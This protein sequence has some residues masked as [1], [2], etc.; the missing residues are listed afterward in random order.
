MLLDI[1]TSFLLINISDTL[2]FSG[3][4][5]SDRGFLTNLDILEEILF[6]MFPE[7]ITQCPELGFFWR[8]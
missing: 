1:H 2:L 7:C 3:N 8:I 6:K 5:L 4:D